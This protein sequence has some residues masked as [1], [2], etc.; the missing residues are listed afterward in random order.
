M[1]ALLLVAGTAAEKGSQRAFSR[2]VLHPSA[3]R[4]F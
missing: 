1:L 4:F 2:N 3:W